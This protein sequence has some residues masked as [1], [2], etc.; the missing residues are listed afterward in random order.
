MFD[1][2]SSL[3]NLGQWRSELE[4]VTGTRDE[5]HEFHIAAC[6]RSPNRRSSATKLSLSSGS[7]S[8]ASAS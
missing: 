4:F 7:I 3:E 8:S 2:P 1:R 6:T 5:T